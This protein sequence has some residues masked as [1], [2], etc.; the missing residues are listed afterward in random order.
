MGLRWKEQI[1]S[2]DLVFFLVIFTILSHC[3][4]ELNVNSGIQADTISFV[5]NVWLSVLS[6]NFV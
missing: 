3:Y 4:I 5:L 1:L 2:V 6:R